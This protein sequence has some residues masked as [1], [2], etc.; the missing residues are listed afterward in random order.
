MR[1]VISALLLW[2]LVTFSGACDGGNE[3]GAVAERDSL[4]DEVVSQFVTEETDSG[5]VRWRLSAPKARRYS[6]EDVFLLDDPT[7]E[8]YDDYGHLQTTLTSKHG[9][10]SRWTDMLA[11]GDVVVVTVDGDVLETDTLRYVSEDDKIISDSFVKLTRGNDVMTGYGLECDHN[12][13]SVE[14]KRNVQATIIDDEG[15]IDDTP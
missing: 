2:A 7:I 13:S 12:L 3:G 15:N 11:Y 14:I 4:P 5:R 9:E 1:R 6:E 10:T 8:F